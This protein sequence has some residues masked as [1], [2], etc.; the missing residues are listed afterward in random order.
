MENPVGV[1]QEAEEQHSPKIGDLPEGLVL[2]SSGSE[3][4]QQ[5]DEQEEGEIQDDDDE[6]EIGCRAGQQLDLEDISSEEESNIRERMA[7]LEAMDKQVG[8]IK[9]IT[10][11]SSYDYLNDDDAVY[12]KENYLYYYQQKQHHRN[13]NS[14]KSAKLPVAKKHDHRRETSKRVE[15]LRMHI[16]SKRH[17]EKTKEKTKR[18]SHKKHKRR[19]HVVPSSPSPQRRVVSS[20]SEPEATVDREY[21]KIACATEKMRKS[22]KLHGSKNPL[23]DKLLLLSGKRREEGAQVEAPVIVDSSSSGPEGDLEDEEELQLRLL[24]LSTKPIVRESGYSEVICDLQLPSPPPPPSIID[25]LDEDDLP[26]MPMAFAP[27]SYRSEERELRLI[28]LKS[29]VMKK[30]ETRLKR[31]EQDAERPYSPS[32]DIV[33]TPVRE[34]PPVYDELDNDLYSDGK[35]SV[36]IV[37]D[38][39]DVLIVET[40]CE[41]IALDDTDEE[42]AE[43][44][45]RDMEISSVESPVPAAAGQDNECCPNDMTEDS[46]QPIDMELASSEHSSESFSESMQHGSIRPNSMLQIGFDSCDS[47]LFTRR[48]TKPP[49]SP[50]MTPDSMEEAEAEAL[51]QLLLT[52]M[53]QKQ[54][55]KTIQEPIPEEPVTRDDPEEPITRDDPEEPITRDDPEATLNL[56]NNVEAMPAE[57]AESTVQP[58]QEES[59]MAYG[60]AT[61]QVGE[62]PSFEENPPLPRKSSQVASPTVN[63]NLITLVNR[64]TAMRKR[65]KKSQSI[66]SSGVEPD[67]GSSL[68]ANK[69]LAIATLPSAARPEPLK[70]SMVRTQ[71]LVNNPNKLINLNQTISPS[72][73]LTRTNSPNHL[74]N[75]DTLV[76]RPVAKLVIQLGNSDSDSDVDFGSPSPA[77]GEA[78][79]PTDG[80]AMPTVRF[81]EQLDRFLKSVRSKTSVAPSNGDDNTKDYSDHSDS[82]S[83]MSKGSTSAKQL[84]PKPPAKRSQPISF[85]GST[86]ASSTA[87]KHLPKSAQM[88]YMRLVARMAQLEQHKLARQRGPTTAPNEANTSPSSATKRTAGDSCEEAFDKSSKVSGRDQLATKSPGKRKHSQSE[89]QSTKAPADADGNLIIQDPME[90]KLQQIRTSIP[91]LSQSSRNRLLLT[92]EK[93]LEKHS[94]TFLQELEQHNSTILSAQHERRELFQLDSR[95]ELLKEKL[96]ILERAREQQ[97][98]RSVDTFTILQASHRKIVT[99]RKRASELERMCNEIGQR[100]VGEEYQ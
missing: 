94:G 65:R 79:L 45:G 41:L 1:R 52:K 36:E 8:L 67:A 93:Q 49:Q 86:T 74:T 21:L 28:A 50:P 92:A 14:H 30:H 2:V 75:G 9:K 26:I 34:V 38:D 83:N 91:N 33:L 29:A 70:A 16:H 96:A 44:G 3:D 58:R 12:G 53:R 25:T 19:K 57:S 20:D 24:A 4:G 27:E 46:Q 5:D 80:A 39:N 47:E 90:R 97:R 18:S 6:E 35:A 85:A 7:V 13:S 69:V 73:P 61:E 77:E 72:P 40:P 54:N 66:K 10:S 98:H 71:K 89:V 100:I 99:S 23:K 42:E 11:R 56:S 15:S 59:L 88:E 82:G 68:T 43:E 78:L 31:K 64:S 76:S 55:Q 51:R 17:L 95:I 32:D 84:Q 81:E 87:V 22:E 37:E 62:G 60:E 63:P 48:A